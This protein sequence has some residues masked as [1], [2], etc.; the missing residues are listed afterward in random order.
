MVNVKVG[1]RVDLNDRVGFYL[2]YG[3]AITGERW[4][5]DVLRLD[6]RWLY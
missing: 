4:Y 2:G 5:T 1:G 3:R 6:V